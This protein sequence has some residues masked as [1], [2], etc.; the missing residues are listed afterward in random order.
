MIELTKLD[1]SSILLNLEMVKYI[2]S[3][4]DTLITF[5]NGETILVKETTH[6][7]EQKIIQYKA[8]ILKHLEN[9]KEK[10]VTTNK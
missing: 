2:E 9:I 6:D 7:L 4:P 8:N 10:P 1:D 3:V 5:I